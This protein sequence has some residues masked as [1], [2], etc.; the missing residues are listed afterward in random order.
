MSPPDRSRPTGERRRPEPPNSPFQDICPLTQAHDA[1][2]AGAYPFI[3]SGGV[4]E[5]SIAPVLKTG[6]RSRGPWV[7]IPPPPLELDVRTAP[8]RL[9]FRVDRRATKRS[10]RRTCSGDRGGGRSA[11]RRLRP[12]ARR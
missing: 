12:S 6:V 10:R 2:A 3:A 11:G 1:A 9:R 7:R 5:W 8:S 4:A